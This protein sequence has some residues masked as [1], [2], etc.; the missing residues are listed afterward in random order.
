[1]EKNF[2]KE[3]NPHEY[4]LAL[5]VSDSINNMSFNYDAFSYFMGKEHRAL[6]AN[7]SDLCFAWLKQCKN[8]YENGIFD[9]R[10]EFEC[11]AAKIMVDSIEKF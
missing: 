5:K 9:G 4:E 1:M 8:Q 10:N 2:T 7:F 6:Q 3:S 11:K